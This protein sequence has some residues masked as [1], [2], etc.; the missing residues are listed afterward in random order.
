M[1]KASRHG[2][3]LQRSESCDDYNKQILGMAPEERHIPNKKQTG[4]KPEGKQVMHPSQKKGLTYAQ[5]Q[6]HRKHSSSGQQWFSGG[7]AALG[8]Q[9]AGRNSKHE[10]S[11][12]NFSGN[13]DLRMDTSL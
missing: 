6:E 1:E 2:S 10:G 11:R 3:A 7:P 13:Q 5:V 12:L 9:E 8:V 4:L